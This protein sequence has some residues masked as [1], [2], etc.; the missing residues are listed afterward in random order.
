MAL[1]ES[2]WTYA[3]MRWLRRSI[4]LLVLCCAAYLATSPAGGH[5]GSTWLGY[6]LGTIC[7]A[8]ML[9]LTWFGVRKRSYHNAGA[10]LRGWLSAHVYLGL[11]LV[12][13]VPLHCGFQFGPNVHTLAYVLMLAVIVSGIVG[14]ST[15]S[16]V[17]ERMTENRPG[18]KLAALLEQIAEIDTEC[19]GMAETLPDGVT[20]AI[21]VSIEETR[22]GG[23]LMRQL[24]GADPRCGTARA[25]DLV[26]REATLIEGAGRAQVQKVLEILSVKRAL[27]VRVRKDIRYRSLMEL[28]LVFHVP[29]SVATLVAVAAHIFIVFYYR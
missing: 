3:E 26:A 6:T 16:T 4:A 19:L 15:Y 25:L 12:L 10:P 29:L 22:L 13:L 21:R 14:V 23:G 11:T 8:L 17:P 9:W 27:V 1:H 18:E 24:A 20:S 5:N 2:F 7:A 28:W